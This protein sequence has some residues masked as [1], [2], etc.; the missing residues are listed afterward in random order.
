MRSVGVIC[1]TTNTVTTS[2]IDAIVHRENLKPF[3]SPVYTSS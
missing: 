2:T 1:I 3:F